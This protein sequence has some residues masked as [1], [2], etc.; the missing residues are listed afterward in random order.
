MKKTVIFSGIVLVSLLIFGMGSAVQAQPDLFVSEFSLSPSQPR[1]DRPVQVRVGVY[2]RGNVPS[3][4]FLVEWWP[5]ENYS[6]PACSWRVDRLAARGGRILNCTYSGYPSWYARL[7]SKVVVDARNEVMEVN[8][9]NNVRRKV[10]R[11]RRAHAG[12]PDL[13]ISE[14]SLSPAQP[15]QGQPVRVRVGVYNRGNAPSGPFLV[16]WWPGENYTSPACSWRIESLAARG[17]R[18]L[19]CTY[20]GYPSWYARL[21]T[22]AIADPRGEVSEQREGNNARTMVIR[23]LR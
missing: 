16:E 23:V 22:K 1:Q 10:I 2:N 3:G 4:P 19:H 21:T 20:S 6:A 11:V 12:R 18:I 8:E 9:G 14:L 13:R 17:G 5:G 7:T 15:R